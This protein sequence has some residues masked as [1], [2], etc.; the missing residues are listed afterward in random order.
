MAKDR[1]N[2]GDATSQGSKSSSTK[3]KKSAS[4]WMTLTKAYPITQEDKVQTVHL[5][6]QTLCIGGYLQLNLL[7]RTQRQEADDRYYT[8]LGYVKAQGL[9]VYNFRFVSK[10]SSR[11]ESNLDPDSIHSMDSPFQ[12]ALVLVD[13]L[14][15]LG[16]LGEWSEQQRCAEFRR[17]AAALANQPDPLDDFSGSELGSDDMDLGIDEFDDLDDI[18]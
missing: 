1:N 8:C 5:P 11:P 16:G 7:G 14:I 3:I 6:P 17:R 10:D 9:P 2:H 12:L 18:L 15:R 4:D 13:P